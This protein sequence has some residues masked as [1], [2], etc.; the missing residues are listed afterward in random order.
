MPEYAD[1][2]PDGPARRRGAAI[3]PANRFETTRYYLDGDWL[4]VQDRDRPPR[5]V[6]LEV[7]ADRTRTVLNR[8][9]PTS[10]VPFDWTLNPY[11]GC[12]HGCI[13]CY[14][15]P[16]HEF[17]GY[18]SGLDFETKLVAKHEA[19]ELLKRELASDKWRAE[20]IVMSAITD[21]Y[22]PIE[23][24]L[25][26]TRRCL[27][28]LVKARQPTSTMTKGALVLRDLDLW[29]ELASFGAARVTV[30]LVTLDDTLAKSL[31]PRAASP[32]RRLAMIRALRA[33]NVPVSVNVAPIIPGLTD[34][35]LPAILEAVAEA[36]AD[37]ASWVLLRLPYQLKNLW[38]DW[39]RRELHPARAARVESR[40]RQARNG[41]LYDAE[42]RWNPRGEIS[43][44]IGDVFRLF[45]RRYG[46]EPERQPLSN[47]RFV[48]PH[49]P[50]QQ[51]L[52]A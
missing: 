17:L 30:T 47:A 6:P 14:A 33:A 1:A 25:G 48:R 34:S 12:E 37:S 46:L 16:F 31:E 35:E 51:V 9:S 24:E 42:T 26:L 49:R 10:D 23:A 50:G 40:L 43:K 29:Q 38:L 52:F 18:S 32:K 22:Q 21:V 28:V 27:E 7:V 19:P 4:D 11:R 44:Q 2:L 8:V 3:N 13:Y 36:G 15:R 41:K 45:C 5:R 39:M 20:P